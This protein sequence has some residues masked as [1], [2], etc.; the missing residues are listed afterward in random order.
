MTSNE[1]DTK[2]RYVGWNEALNWIASQDLRGESFD[3]IPIFLITD[4]YISG[5]T[6]RSEGRLDLAYEFLWNKVLKGQIRVI[7][8]KSTAS[9]KVLKG[10]REET[11]ENKYNVIPNNFFEDADFEWDEGGTFYDGNMEYKDIWVC[12]DDLEREFPDS[13]EPEGDKVGN[14]SASTEVV[15]LDT[16]VAKRGRPPKYAWNEFY[17]EIIRLA[18]GIDGLPET[19]A[20]LEATMAEWCLNHWGTEPAESTIRDKISPIYKAIGEGRKF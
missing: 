20:E 13:G 15:R 8:K 3:P 12:F 18:N 2:T 17:V 11:H 5:E 16:S 9:N 6:H 1:I 14:A 10:Q 4:A 19:Q 7:G